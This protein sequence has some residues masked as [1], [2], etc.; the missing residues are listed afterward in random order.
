MLKSI[1]A[2]IFDMDGTLIDSLWVWKQVDIDFLKKRGINLPQNLQ[3]NIE[4]LSFTQTA[5]YFKEKFN[6]EE[7]IDDIEN[8]WIEM[9]KYYYSNEIKIKKGVKE[10]LKYLKKEGYKTA[11]ATSNFIDLT[12]AVLQKNK[13]YEYFDTVVTTGEVDRDKSYP[14]VFLETAKRLNASPLNCMVFE[15]TIAGLT[16]ARAANMKVVA[17][18]D[19]YGTC[20]VDELLKVSDG[21]IEDFEEIKKSLN[22]IYN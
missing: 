16:G 15:D 6:L 3:R 19:S 4:G 9:V 13:I 8:E 1:D 7:S 21:L 20:T 12:T 11:V 14:D 2:V 18:Y 5:L 17:V 22:N 10:F